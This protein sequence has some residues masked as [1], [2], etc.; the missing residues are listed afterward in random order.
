[1]TAPFGSKIDKII[2]LNEI[3]P[4]NGHTPNLLNLQIPGYT[5]HTNNLDSDVRGTCIYVSNKFKSAEVKIENHKFD[6]TVSV[7]ISGKNQSK[8]IVSCIY[9]SGTPQ[10]ALIK[11]PEMYKL[12]RSLNA[13]TGYQMKIIVGDFNLNRITWSPDPELPDLISEDSAEYKF[14]ECI[15]D[16]FMYQHITEPTRYCEG[17]RPTCDDLLFSS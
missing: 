11:D 5:L 15:R 9:R 16:T 4:K 12:L 6:D 13:T 7:E 1:M 8:I 17:N 14:I 10:R 3:N 2:V